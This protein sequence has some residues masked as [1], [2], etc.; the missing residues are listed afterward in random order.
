[1]FTLKD[2]AE[3]YKTISNAELLDILQRPTGYQLIAIQA[4]KDEFA[5]R[6]LSEQDIV[7]AKQALHDKQLQKGKQDENLQRIK[8]KL[9][10]AGDL[11]YD[12]LK[13][14]QESAPTSKKIIIF[15]SIGFS[16]LT[17]YEFKIFYPII[18]DLMSGYD[19]FGFGYTLF[20]FPIL[21]LL[22]GTLLFCFRKQSGWVILGLY[23]SASVVAELWSLYNF[24]SFEFN[25]SRF[26]IYRPSASA[27][28]VSLL[29]YGATLLVFCRQ[30]IKE[31]YRI[32]RQNMISTLVAGG[33]FGIVIILVATHL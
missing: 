30:D 6:Q 33:L 3:R 29:I 17:I 2:F 28:I 9:N 25:Q 8:A 19:H 12:N 16:L 27:P 5:A 10:D 23:C 26:A 24:F 18:K 21:I 7:D 31:I 13:P 4:A 22:C 20:L 14:D 32:D 1:M 11:L 15:L